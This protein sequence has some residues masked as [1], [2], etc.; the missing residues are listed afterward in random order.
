MLGIRYSFN[1]YMAKQIISKFKDKN[2]LV[3]LIDYKN[4]IYRPHKDTDLMTLD[5]HIEISNILA[6][7]INFIETTYRQF[8]KHFELGV[9]F[10]FYGE[11]GKSNYHKSIYK[12]YKANRQ[13]DILSR[14]NIHKLN[15]IIHISSQFIENTLNFLPR[16][17]VL[18]ASYLDVDCFNYFYIKHKLTKDNG[19][20]IL[21][22][23]KDNMQILQYFDNVLI[24]D[25]GIKRSKKFLQK[26]ILLDRHNFLKRLLDKHWDDEIESIILKNKWLS[27]YRAIIGDTSDNIKGVPRVGPSRTIDVLKMLNKYD[28]LKSM[29]IIISELSDYYTQ[30]KTHKKIPF[31]IFKYDFRDITFDDSDEKKMKHIKLLYDNEDIIIRNLYMMDYEIISRVLFNRLE[32]IHQTMINYDKIKNYREY[33]D[34]LYDIK[35]IF[36][37]DI[38]KISYSLKNFFED[39]LN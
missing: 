11:Y 28:L 23:D 12:E 7:L 27:L 39:M 31:T 16:T 10:I 32:E 26:E 19:V 4:A 35:L 20:V 13:K 37:D 36:K 6:S 38:Q 8:Y 30:Y 17:N 22:T 3:I 33:M 29:D 21:S 14:E 15:N 34:F 18:Y 24:Y 2:K 9:D 1:D 25:K 5:A